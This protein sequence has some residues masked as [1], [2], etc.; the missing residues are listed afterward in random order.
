MKKQFIFLAIIC[1]FQVFSQKKINND[2]YRILVGTYTKK[3]SEGVYYVSIDKKTLDSKIISHSDKIEDPSFLDISKDHKNVYAVSETD[4]GSVQAMNFDETSGKFT[5]TTHVNSGGAHPCFVTLD[6]TG[7]WL[8]TGNYTGGS[9]GVIKV[10][11]DGTL[12][13]PHQKIQHFGSGPNKERQEKPHVHSVNISP[14][15]KHLFV[16][17]LGTDVV[18]NYSFDPI[19]GKLKEVQRINLS[20]GSGPRHFTFHPTLPFAYVIQELTGKVTL[21]SYKNGFLKVIEEVS[22]LPEGFTGNN[23][24]ADIHISPDGKFL[25]GSNRFFDTLVTFSIDSKTG[26]LKQISQTPV[27]GKVPRNFGITPDGRYVFVANQATDNISIFERNAK[28]GELKFT[29]KEI[30]I[31]MPVCVK[32]L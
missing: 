8:F 26:K 15:N 11:S 1:S 4:G 18:V 13:Q 19:I 21:F 25:Y 5:H 27:E 9:L 29:G 17:D 28:T 12:E 2:S 31:S 6:K 16:A 10:K 3:T 20:A 32:F 22:T 23:S 14:D 7:K 30:K 24:C